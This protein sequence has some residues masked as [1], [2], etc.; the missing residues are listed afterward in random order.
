LTFGL[1]IWQGLGGGFTATAWQSMIGKIMPVNRRGI[2]FGAQSAA[3]NLGGSLSAIMAG[4]LLERLAAPVNFTICFLLAG[5]AMMISWVFLAQTREPESSA[6][7]STPTSSAF[8]GHFRA[9]LQRDISL[10]PGCPDAVAMG[11]MALAS[12]PF[13]RCAIWD[14]EGM[15]A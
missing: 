10:V 9:I 5:I 3:A 1:L 14:S 2:F 12:T 4:L 13:T 6:A 15:P 8:R 11:T 7:G